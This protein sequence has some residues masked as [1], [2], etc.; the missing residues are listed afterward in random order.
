MPAR[1]QS[2]S[3]IGTYKQCPRKYFY[4]YIAALPTAKNIYLIKG[5]LIH[6]V[7]DEFFNVNYDEFTKFNYKEKLREKI[8]DSFKEKWQTNLAEIDA[9]VPGKH[10]IHF[11]DSVIMLSTWVEGFLNRLGF[12]I[13]GGMKFKDAFQRLTPK[14][15]QH[16]V[17]HKHSVRGYIDAIHEE[18]GEVHL[19]DYKT[20]SSNKISDQYYL[21]L[22]IYALLYKEHFKTAPHKVGIHFLRYG[23]Q[24]LPVDEKMIDHAKKEIN[25]IHKNTKSKDKADYPKCKTPLCKWHSGQCDFYHICKEDD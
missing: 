2:P 19:I 21:Q 11:Q 8:M 23:E 3:S 6:E 4:Q 12:F 10:K 18:E 7:L 5:G 16:I 17:N 13:S 14:R 22:A 1:I 15:E 9:L 25:N 24:H 20:S